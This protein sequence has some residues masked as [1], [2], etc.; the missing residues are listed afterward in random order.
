LGRDDEALLSYAAA[1]I[2][3][4]PRNYW[5]GRA[6]SALSALLERI[7]EEGV[8][9][10]YWAR[11]R[12][13]YSGP[14][15]RDVTEEVGL[16]GRSESRVAFGD[17]DGDGYDDVLL[18]GIILYR[19]VRGARFEDVSEEAGIGV[20]EG[21]G[22]IFADYD[23][24]GH[25]D[26]F[27]ASGREGLGGDRL[28]HNMGDGTFEDVTRAAGGVANDWPTEGV[29]FGDV[30]IDGFLDLY[31]ANY[32]NWSE[33]S[34]HPDQFFLNRGDGT[35]Q[36]VAHERGMIPPRDEPRAGRGVSMADFD[37]DGDS[38]IFVCNYRLHENFLWRNDGRLSFTNVAHRLGV[39]GEEVRG[40][41]GHTIGAD[42]GDY[43]GDGDLDLVAANLAHPRY[44][45]FSDR[46]KLY[47]NQGPPNWTF[48][49]RRAR[50]GIKYDEC[51][52]DPLF[53]D[54]DADGDL[55]LYITS[56]YEN[57]GSH[58]YLNQGDG[59][60]E[61]VTW[62]SGTRAFNTWGCAFSDYDKDGDLD[63]LVG[64]TSGV[65]LFQNQGGSNH[66]LE[67]LVVGAPNNSSGIGARI[68]VSHKGVRQ[69]QIREIRAG[70]GTTSQSSLTSFF[71]LGQN[72]DPVTLKI[73]FPSGTDR[74]LEG[75]QPDQLLIVTESR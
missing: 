56:I 41:Y 10:L 26:L 3:G 46:T 67:V 23:N 39:A 6:D 15:F 35:F 47:E 63:L 69:S 74:L 21:S 70:K 18:D 68:E 60:F 42:W 7:G 25:L 34:Y 12:L 17:Y 57:R 64:S 75:V 2:E 52:S 61:D 20:G 16:S 9:P 32:E 54:F 36:E 55:D 65:R 5:T 62:L 14:V 4:D 22:G 49:D 40:Y 71:G 44:I 1:M 73:H 19:N 27:R 48:V 59:T 30:D 24:D 51:H 72:R 58:L 31:L 29:A 66:W 50:A 53:A 33:H 45:E 11:E 13:G 43:D 38:D 28:F 37:D 8:D